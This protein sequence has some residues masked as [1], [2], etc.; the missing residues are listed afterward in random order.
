MSELPARLRWRMVAF[1]A[2]AAVM[3]PACGGRPSLGGWEQEWRTLAEGIP[4]AS[5]AA[6]PPG[7]ARC[8]DY[9]A[10]LRDT[11][12][13]LRPAPNDVLESAAVAWAEFG[14]SVFFECPPTRGEHAGW[15][16]AAL[17]LQRLLAEVEAEIAFEK[18]V[19]E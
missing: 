9:L 16:A 10:A 5:L 19:Q 4:V 13:D 15:E 6:D 1:G 18:S 7:R 8:D 14:E 11:L 2:V 17:E 3:I 12:P